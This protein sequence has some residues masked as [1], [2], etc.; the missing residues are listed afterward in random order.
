[1]KL[2]W[3]IDPTTAFEWEWIQYLLHPMKYEVVT[4]MECN[5]MH[6]TPC[7]VFNHSFRDYESVFEKYES[8][9]I[10][11]GVIHLS[12]ETLG[13]TCNY[14]HHVMCRFAI[15]NYHHPV[16]SSHPKMK[17]IGLGWKV[18]FQPQTTPPGALDH[19]WYHWCFAGALHNPQRLEALQ[20]FAGV[21]PYLCVPAGTTFNSGEG[22][23]T[24]TYR[25]MFMH[26]KFAI[27]PIGQGNLDTFRFY[28]ALEAGCIPVVLNATPEQPYNSLGFV[29]Y[30]HAMFPGEKGELPWVCGDTWKECSDKVRAILRDPRAYHELR[31]LSQAFWCKWK[32][33]WS[34]WLQE[35]CASLMA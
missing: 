18:G 22:F 13:D 34:E 20:A 15:R 29:S 12:D 5:L 9:H 27:C 6:E 33:K 7:F 14:L 26:S 2:V 31:S 19:P 1:M 11:Y 24:P 10:P 17:T 23:D 4:D 21:A 32:M 8:Q 30:W 35:A 16:H 25:A 28:E 3:L